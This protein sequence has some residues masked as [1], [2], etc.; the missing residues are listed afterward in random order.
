MP[1]LTM[2]VVVAWLAMTCHDP[3]GVRYQFWYVLAILGQAR[4]KGTWTP[5]GC[6]H[7]GKAVASLRVHHHG[8]LPVLDG[9]GP[10]GNSRPPAF[11]ERV[12]DSLTPGKP[13][14]NHRA[15]HAQPGTMLHA[16]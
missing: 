12:V 15:V 14:A 9:Q 6:A 13:G 3:D 4:T 7:A 1:V 2:L 5:N 16:S 11:P 10:R 8:N